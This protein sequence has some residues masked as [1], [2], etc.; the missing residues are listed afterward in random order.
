[1]NLQPGNEKVFAVYPELLESAA[2]PY[3]IDEPSN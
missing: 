1:M 3:V 2:M